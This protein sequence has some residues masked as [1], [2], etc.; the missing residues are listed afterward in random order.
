MVFNRYWLMF[1]HDKV[2]VVNNTLTSGW[3][4]RTTKFYDS[5]F[6][7]AFFLK[8]LDGF[9]KVYENKGV[10]VFKRLPEPPNGTPEIPAPAKPFPNPHIPTYK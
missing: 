1:T 9:E 7:K 3:E 6:Y 5:N 10:V 8:Q 4:D 2:W